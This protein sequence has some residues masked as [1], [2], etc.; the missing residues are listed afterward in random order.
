MKFDDLLHVVAQEPIFES[1][2]LLAGSVDPNDLRRQLS[3]W[4]RAGRVVQIR[5]GLYALASP[6]ARA[7]PHPFLVANR[8]VRGSYV[9]CQ[10]ALAHHG[11]IPESVPVVTS[12][13]AGRPARWT[14]PLGGFEFRHVKPALLY[15]YETIDVGGQPALVARPEKALLDLVHLT[16]GG[17]SMAFLESLRL[18]QTE[19]FDPAALDE[20]A[21]RAR[22]PKLERA[23]RRLRRLVTGEAQEYEPA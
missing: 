14:T 4:T 1:A 23:A 7:R 16:P 6:H 5:R 19:R 17:D 9:S 11:V 8:L 12:V 13:A 2:L 18:Q 10:S 22:R 15:G 20:M 21:R 3:R